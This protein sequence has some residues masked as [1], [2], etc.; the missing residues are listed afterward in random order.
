MPID[1]RIPLGVESFSLPNT[2][3]GVERIK[4]SRK[5]NELADLALSRAKADEPLETAQRETEI[6][7]QRLKSTVLGAERLRVFVE[8]GDMAGAL[9]DLQSR[10]ATLDARGTDS[11]DTDRA[12]AAVQ[13][14]ISTG[15]QT[16]LKAGLDQARQ[17]GTQYGLIGSRA[18]QAKPSASIEA[19]NK[20]VAQAQ[21]AGTEPLPYLDP[22][23]PM[24]FVRQFARSNLGAQ[25]GAPSN[26]PG[27]GVV[28]PSRV[29]PANN[30]TLA[31]EPQ[32]S[33]AGAQ[34]AGAEA[35]AKTTGTGEAERALDMPRARAKLAATNS[36]FDR[37]A[38]VVQEVLDDPNLWQAVGIGKGLSSIPGSAGA[39]LK[40]KIENIQSQAGLAVLQDMRD[41]SSTGGAVGQVSN[42]EQQIFQN[43]IAN[44]GNLNQ[45][46][47][48]FRDQLRKLKAF[49]EGSKE[50][51]SAAFESLY[52]GISKSG[53]SDFQ[54]QYDAL[55]SGAQYTAP[56]GSVRTKR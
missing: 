33:T 36:K 34:R 14:A 6:D 18:N 50:R 11:S 44:L 30:V 25:F 43:N 45:S 5:Q 47:E 54:S 38:T 41:N 40:A 35:E 42:F 12:I 2:M 46:P 52:P 55:P 4:G 27:I 13:E 23:S 49:S 32:V 53:E 8:A 3:L 16:K 39:D 26:Q 17:V 56:D 1:P 21:A 31:T 15:D 9:A 20:H 24:D 10:K 19:Y 51:F 48:N 7:L 22:D 29:D 37:L 28:Q